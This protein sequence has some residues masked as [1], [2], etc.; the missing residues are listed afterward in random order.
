MGAGC[1]LRGSCRVRGSF[2]VLGRSMR[3]CIL[4]LGLI[5]SWGRRVESSGLCCITRVWS[6]ILRIFCRIRLN[7]SIFRLFFYRCWL[8]SLSIGTFISTQPFSNISPNSTY[9]SSKP[10][11]SNRQPA[12]TYP[13][14]RTYQQLSTTSKPKA[15]SSRHE[16]KNIQQIYAANFSHCSWLP[17]LG[18]L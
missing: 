12:D 6:A 10:D 16:R 2:F 17:P 18:T 15:A 14:Y 5:C 8:L 1:G 9:S 4:C 11:H 3:S 7:L 13:D